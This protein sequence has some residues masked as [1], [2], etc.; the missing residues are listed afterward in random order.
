MERPKSGNKSSQMSLEEFISL[1]A[2]LLDM[3]KV[4]SLSLK[5]FFVVVFFFFLLFLLSPLL[6]MMVAIS[7]AAV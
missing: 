6:M 1:T 3:E 7:N 4:S 5:F 2:P